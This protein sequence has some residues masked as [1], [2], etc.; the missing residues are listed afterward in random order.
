MTTTS[1]PGSGM[2]EPCQPIGCDNGIHVSGCFFEAIDAQDKDPWPSD[3]EIAAR[4]DSAALA[5]L[6]EL[7]RP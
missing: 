7:G 6:E 3:A 5:E 2:P 4:A 1:Y